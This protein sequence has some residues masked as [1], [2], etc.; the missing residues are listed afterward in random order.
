[1]L[2]RPDGQYL[3]VSKGRIVVVTLPLGDGGETTLVVSADE[4]VDPNERIVDI[5]VA[6]G[7][8]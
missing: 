5:Y 6:K 7:G 2:Y 8:L 3:L 4:Q 1:L